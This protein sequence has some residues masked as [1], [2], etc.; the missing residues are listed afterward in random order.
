MKK[1]ISLSLLMLL[2]LSALALGQNITTAEFSGQVISSDNQP[3]PGVTIKAVHVPTGT[4]F[5]VL[6]RDDGHFNIPAVRVGGP[7]TITATLE[8]FKEEE[9]KDVYVK[10]GENKLL[11]I[12]LNLANVDL[13]EVTV[14]ATE[15]LL[16][17]AQ[18]G[19][20]E[21]VTENVIESMPSI[22]RN[23]SDF[24]R[25]VPQVNI[26]ENFSDQAYSVA[27]RNNRY[28][29]VQIDGAV[30]NDLFG[31]AN[32]G[33]PGGQAGTT[34]I[35]LDAIQEFQIVIA[36]YDVR[37]GG[38]TGGGINAIT[39]SGTNSFHGSAF[40]Y[41]RNQDLVGNGPDDTQYGQ[42]NEKQMGFR[43]GGPIVQDKLFFF[44]NAEFTRRS[45]PVDY[46]IDDSG[47]ANDFGGPNVSVA[48]A[49]RFTQLC[50]GYGF[51]PGTYGQASID[52]NSNKA[53]GR[54]DYNINTANRL[55]VRFNFVDAQ[56]GYLSR[57]AFS[58]SYG[59]NNYEFKSKTYSTV[60]QLDS[61]FGESA[62]NE[63]R[64]NYTAIREERAVPLEAPQVRVNIS[65]GYSFYA[66]TERYSGANGLDQDVLEL[67]D[68]MTFFAGKH[69][70]VIGTHN[71]LFKFS[72]LFIRDIYG[73]W[74]FSN[75]DNFEA[76]IA[77][78]YEH[79]FS[80]VAG[81]PFWEASFPVHQIGVYAGD[82]WQILPYLN[83]TYGVRADIP[84]MPDNP[85]A[86][87]TVAATAYPIAGKAVRTDWTATGNILWSPRAGF[88]WDVLQNQKTLLRGGIGMFAGRTPYVWI[89]NNY[90]NTGIEFTRYDIRS[91][92]P[93]FVSD[94]YNQPG[95]FT[96]AANEIDLIDDQFKFPEV[97]R[98]DLAVDQE[99][100]WDM[101]FT[102]E[103][104]YSKNI[105]D[106]LT[107]NINLKLTGND[108]FDG[109]P[110]YK[111]RVSPGF[112]DVIYLTNSTQGY[113]YDMSFSLQKRFP[114]GR[115]YA[116]AAYTY[117]VATDQTSSTSS[118]ARSNFQY[119]H[120]SWDP[121]H[122]D[123]VKS[124]FDVRHR[125]AIG[126]SYNVNPFK[127]WDSILGMFLNCRSGRPYSSRYS[128][129]VNGDGS[130][131]NDTVYVPASAD[132]I[133]LT[134]GTWADL[135]AYIEGDPGLAAARGTIIKRNASREP[136]YNRM[137]FRYLQDIPIPKLDGH[138]LQ[139]SMDI[140]N[141][142]NLFNKDW[143]RYQ[144]VTYTGDVPLSYSGIDAATGKAKMGFLKTGVNRYSTDQLLSRWQMQLG[145]RY[146]F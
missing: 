71:E 5:T 79:S 40:F 114:S 17:T 42:F 110:L 26:S 2:L 31:L 24:A 145:I 54:I 93:A 12:K 142:L 66:G 51:D 72:N 4:V 23:F 116:S 13:G 55:T 131:Y 62:S 139:F 36:P 102:W 27:G 65:G 46:V 58:F 104:V 103:Q 7:Y 123:L 35:S 63:L 129:D 124:N 77:S 82:T 92:V 84:L 56:Q 130:S 19:A 47:N 37:Q 117:G 20:A 22:S 98:L 107:Q 126:A 33:T 29:N 41:Y 38:F 48:D 105:N 30:N 135:N 1:H 132:E 16:S 14:V 83:I 91:G 108:P 80:N 45:A 115:G 119:N 50:E 100:P 39:R 109:R 59:N 122:P 111:S 64:V 88:N 21:N 86:N 113:Q 53:F 106:C 15:Q 94:P 95:G 81:D 18:T 9:F 99:L 121:N 137:D 146:T 52:R 73:A 144:Y 11:N 101:K 6:T 75:M 60:G 3:L 89:S 87:P 133:I 68:N 120:A 34:P 85:T 112:S 10:L 8:G 69:T 90:G 28:N 96:A 76:G 128:T 125:I 25:L 140:L 141:F 32:S 67:T 97:L 74:E 70:I 143:G 57:S 43:L 138:K 61:L 78:R 127:G 49:Q 44:A 134:Q 136:W 118:Q